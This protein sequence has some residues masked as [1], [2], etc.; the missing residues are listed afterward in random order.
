MVLHIS[1]AQVP[2]ISAASVILSTSVN[3]SSVSC[4]LKIQ[5]THQVATY[6]TSALT[7]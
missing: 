2:L 5:N 4:A 7:T 3:Q 6:E 1:E